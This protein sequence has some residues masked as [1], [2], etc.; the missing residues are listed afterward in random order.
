ME[1]YRY[2]PQGG[3]HCIATGMGW[4][5]TDLPTLMKYAYKSTHEEFKKEFQGAIDQLN[6]RKVDW[7]L[8]VRDCLSSRKF[9]KQ[10]IYDKPNKD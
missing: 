2:T 8:N 7:Y 4:Y 1:K 3:A 5:P 9:L 6:K 10:K